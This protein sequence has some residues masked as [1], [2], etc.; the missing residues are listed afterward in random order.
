MC[1][2]VSVIVPVLS[3]NS[4]NR[5][6]LDSNMLLVLFLSLEQHT[7]NRLSVRY[8]CSRIAAGIAL[9]YENFTNGIG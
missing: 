4:C 6:N 2:Y 5:A 8:V 7:T 1:V 9:K 3:P